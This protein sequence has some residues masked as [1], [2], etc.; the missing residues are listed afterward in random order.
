MCLLRGL[1]GQPI[2]CFMSFVYSFGVILSKKQRG[3]PVRLRPEPTVCEDSCSPHHQELQVWFRTIIPTRLCLGHWLQTVTVLIL[4]LDP[5][6][7]RPTVSHNKVLCIFLSCFSFLF[8]FLISYCLSCF[9]TRKALH[10]SED[11]DAVIV[12]SLDFCSDYIDNCPWISVSQYTPQGV[13]GQPDCT[14]KNDKET[15]CES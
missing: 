12:G 11:E 15:V 2:S 3:K 9:Q 14:A 13:R 5:E 7:Q 10:F 6:P 4:Y 1:Q 8:F